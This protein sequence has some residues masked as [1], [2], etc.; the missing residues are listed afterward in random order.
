MHATKKNTENR[1]L[2]KIEAGEAEIWCTSAVLHGETENIDETMLTRK[3]K[4]KKKRKDERRRAL[5]LP[6]LP[7]SYLRKELGSGIYVTAL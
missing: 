2:T 3:K 1:D 7:P 6:L 5:F 4:R